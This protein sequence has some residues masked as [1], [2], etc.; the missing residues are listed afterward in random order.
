MLTYCLHTFFLTLSCLRYA[1]TQCNKTVIF[2][3]RTVRCSENPVLLSYSISE[4]FS[5]EL[6]TWFCLCSFPWAKCSDLGAD[7][8]SVRLRQARLRSI[9][10]MHTWIWQE[11]CVYLLNKPELLREELCFTRALLD[12]WFFLFI[13]CFFPTWSWQETTVEKQAYCQEFKLRGVFTLFRSP[14][15]ENYCSK[16]FVNKGCF[17]FQSG[18][19]C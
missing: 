16:W 4:N 9:L 15:L 1:L 5:R 7:D 17:L 3:N 8:F 18:C 6:C 12:Q 11:C 19:R 13:F 10:G 2:W 14:Q